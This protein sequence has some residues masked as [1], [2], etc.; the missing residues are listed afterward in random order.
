MARFLA[1]VADRVAG[2]DG[3]LARDRAGA[4]EDRFEQR[5]LAALERTDQRDAAGTG[6]ARAIAVAVCRHDRLPQLPPENGPVVPLLSPRTGR[7]GAGQHR[8]R[9][10]RGRS[11]GATSR[12][13]GCV[14]RPAAELCG[15]QRC[16][17]YCAGCSSSA[18]MPAAALRPTWPWTESGCNAT[19]R[20]EPPIKRVGAD[21]G[22]DGRFRLRP[23]IGAGQHADIAVGAG[24]HRPDDGAAGGERRRR[25]RSSSSCRYRLPAA[26]YPAGRCNSHCAAT[27][28]S[29]RRRPKPSR[30][31]CRPGHGSP[32]HERAPLWPTQ[33]PPPRRMRLQNP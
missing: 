14:R 12:C 30:P 21:A 8:F 1:G 6:R 26:R 13:R 29:G 22:A 18:P 19:V 17:A 27:R 23:G 7:A 15:V 20:F 2:F 3:A 5:G 25:G 16:A 32:A 31:T 33:T 11:R 9:R 28:R 4:G 10:R 24:K